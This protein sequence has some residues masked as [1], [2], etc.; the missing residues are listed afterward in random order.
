MLHTKT[1]S[2]TWFDINTIMSK[3][4]QKY[5]KDCHKIWRD[6]Y[7]DVPEG[8][9]LHHIVPRHAGGQ[10]VL[11]N[12]EI[13]TSA[14]HKER[15]LKLYEKNGDFRDL[16]AYHMIGYNFTEAH[17]IS[18]SEGGKAGGKKVYEEGIG[19]FRS[20]EE[21]RVWA[22][23]AGKIGGVTQR[24][25]KLGIHGLTKEQNRIN[26]S[27]GGKKGGFTN[28][29]IQRKLGKRGGPK[30]KG[31]VWLTNGVDTIKYSP[32]QQQ[33]KSV[34]QFLLEN[35]EY[36]IGRAQHK[37]VTCPYCQKTGQPGA[38]AL[39]HFENCKKRKT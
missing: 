3:P 25:N 15:H 35:K 4:K 17:R 27:K 19:I 32:K 29:E 10:D 34:E 33:L 39:H 23:A 9:E 30:N 6:A 36:R 20:K 7:G 37:P 38:M 26:S 24:D 12:L 18:S 1:H 13:V 5:R 31:F 16:C 28:P 21:R 14:E 11:E 2:P 22:S 8:Y